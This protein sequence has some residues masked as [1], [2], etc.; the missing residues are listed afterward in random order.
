MAGR[1][2]I[3]RDAL[4]E[5]AA[6]GYR[7]DLFISYSSDDDAWVW[8]WLLPRLEAAGLNVCIDRACFE[9]GAPLADEAERAIRESRH[10]LV[11]LSPGWV[12]SQWDAFEGLIVHSQ[13]PAARLRRLIPLLLAPCTPPERIRSLSAIDLTRPAE[14]EAQLA[15]V[16]AYVQGQ[17]D[18]PELRFETIVAPAQRRRELRWYAVAAVSAFL[19]LVLLAAWIF[20]Q[21]RGP[22]AM[23]AG[24]FNIA[25]AAFQA[26][27][28]AGRPLRSDAGVTRA[29]SIA[30][31]LEGQGDALGQIVGKAV[32]IWGPDQGVRP[33]LPGEEAARARALQASVLLYG[34]VRQLTPERWQ[35]EPAFYLTDEA[36]R[37][38]D[39]LRGEYALGTKIAYRPAAAAS[40]KEVNQTMEARLL[41]LGQILIGL[42]YYSEGSAAGYSK[43]TAAFQRAAEDPAWGASPDASG[44]EVLFL[45]LGNAY[46]KQA[47][48]SEDDAAERQ[49]LLTASRNAYEQAIARNAN[50]PR[51]YNGLGGVFFQMARP[52]ASNPDPCAWQWDLLAEAESAYTKALSLPAE[53]KPPSGFVDLRAHMGL[54][55]ISFWRG[56][57]LDPA[58]WE[59]AQAEYTAAVAAYQALAE[60]DRSLLADQMA[61]AYTDLGHMAYFRALQPSAD[62]VDPLLGEAILYY[63]QVITLA[64]QVGQDDMMEHARRVMPYLLSAYCQS[65]QADAARA[66]LEQFVSR[67][68]SPH[69]SRAAI[70]DQMQPATKKGCL[71]E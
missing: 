7:Y 51:S 11:I 25:V 50:Y 13:D 64:V 34:A 27:D 19:T 15:R 14:Q 45:F 62:A 54:G 33:I 40:E 6:A 42:S 38:A 16:I 20:F 67:T 17:R 41:A 66:A 70:L 3:R 60:P 30:H 4:T 9:P 52:L 29:R 32:H 22:T 47:F 48:F 46:T 61:I 12:A 24:D 55:R 26:L 39:E 69:A 56:G 28:A 58:A 68:S 59:Q 23:P 63:S 57:C 1:R 53:T 65:G 21:G 18:L 37:Q 5:T 2:R 35:L 44:Q 10:T 8:E 71:D 36:V 43:A 49:R 31:F